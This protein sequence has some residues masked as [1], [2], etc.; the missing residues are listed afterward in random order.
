MRSLWWALVLYDWCPYKKGHLDTDMDIGRMSCEDR[1]RDEVMLLQ[2]KG[3]QDF[4]DQQ[5]LGESLGQVAPLGPQ[6]NHTASILTLDF[7]LQGLGESQSL[8]FEPLSLWCFVMAAPRD[9]CREVPT[10]LM[11]VTIPQKDSK[12]S[13][14]A[15]VVSHDI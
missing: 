6:R 3:H 7:W 9:S 8:L 5:N 10:P 2:A 4:Y 11:G 12:S 1:G 15:V 13:L 14:K